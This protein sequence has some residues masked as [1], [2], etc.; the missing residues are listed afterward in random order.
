MEVKGGRDM[1]AGV[2]GTNGFALVVQQVRSGTGSMAREAPGMLA[3]LAGLD[4]AAVLSEC[5]AQ[6][7]AVAFYLASRKDPLVEEYNAALLVKARAEHRLGEVLAATVNHAGSRGVGDAVPRPLPEEISRKQS[8]RAQQLARVPW[9]EIA[10]HIEAATAA[11]ERGTPGRFAQQ[12]LR[13]QT[14][15]ERAAERSRAPAVIAG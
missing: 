2:R 4:D 15:R 5:K 1:S 10:G 8:S 12:W 14:R 6:A 9:A 7:A 3:F 13:E 11:N